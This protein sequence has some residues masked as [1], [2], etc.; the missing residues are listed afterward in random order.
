MR[1]STFN[2]CLLFS[3]ALLLWN[4]TNVIELELPE[5]KQRLVVNGVFNPDST[6]SIDI[7]GSQSAL[8]NKPYEQ[9]QHATVGVYQGDR[10]LYNLPHIGNGKY[11]A[12][13]TTPKELEHYTLK[14]SAPGYPEVQASGFAPA[15][16]AVSYLKGK[17]INTS[18]G[19]REVELTFV[20][21]DVP[22]L[23]NYYFISAFYNDTS[24]YNNQVYKHYTSISFEAP[25]EHEFSLGWL[26]FFS[27]KLIDGKSVPLKI[28]T[29]YPGKGKLLYFNIAQASPDYYHYVRTLTKQ[30]TIDSFSHSPTAVHNNIQ[31]GYGVFAGHTIH[32][33]RIRF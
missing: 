17:I 21:N 31:N 11:K 20:L 6:W 9:V 7:S 18:D 23:Q 32:T 8:S 26:Y 13:E 2:L 3:S 16:P 12:Q 28:R 30:A 1:K 24:Y 33:F 15:K 29:G 27:D 14:V 5:H 22:D 10:F 25:V 4:C 19:S